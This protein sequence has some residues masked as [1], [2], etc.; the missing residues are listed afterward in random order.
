LEWIGPQASF[1]AAYP[2]GRLD[3]V[4][5]L[6]YFTFVLDFEVLLESG[7]HKFQLTV[8]PTTQIA[9]L[10]S[11]GIRRLLYKFTKTVRGIEWSST[12]NTDN[13]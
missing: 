2:S 5:K 7:A 4:L 9:I 10:Q 8:I 6:E 12:N 11:S 13:I 3:A 1:L